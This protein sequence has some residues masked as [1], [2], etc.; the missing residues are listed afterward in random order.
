[1]KRKGRQKRKNASALEWVSTTILGLILMNIGLFQT[2]WAFDDWYFRPDY[3]T[4]DDGAFFSGALFIGL[5]LLIFS[6]GSRI[7]ENRSA[8]RLAIWAILLCLGMAPLWSIGVCVMR[9]QT[10]VHYK[11]PQFGVC[12]SRSRNRT[13]YMYVKN[14]DWCPHFGYAISR[15]SPAAEVK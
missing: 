2:I 11:T 14:S 10:I 3:I 13:T 7:A 6:A 1:M 4:D 8:E 12:Y 9:H 5:I 15:P